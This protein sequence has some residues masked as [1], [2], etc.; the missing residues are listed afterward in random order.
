MSP[1]WGH[2]SHQSH[3][4]TV[5]HTADVLGSHQPSSVASS[6]SEFKAA[7]ELGGSLGAVGS[8]QRFS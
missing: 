3:P 2:G 6:G 5:T 8:G 4:G 7:T 1:R